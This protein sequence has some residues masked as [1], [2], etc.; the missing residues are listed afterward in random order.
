MGQGHSEA[1]VLMERE[2]DIL[3]TLDTDEGIDRLTEKRELLRS[4]LT[5]KRLWGKKKKSLSMF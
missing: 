5:T 3:M 2:K 4:L 1:F